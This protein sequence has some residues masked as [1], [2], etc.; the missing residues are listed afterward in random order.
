MQNSTTACF[1]PQ[2]LIKFQCYVANQHC[3]TT[4]HQQTLVFIFCKKNTTNFKCDPLCLIWSNLEDNLWV[5]KKRGIMHCLSILV[6]VFLGE[7]VIQIE[8]MQSSVAT[9]LHIFSILFY[10]K[11]QKWKILATLGLFW[12]MQSGYIAGCIQKSVDSSLCLI[13]LI[14]FLRS[15]MVYLWRHCYNTFSPFIL[16]ATFMLGLEPL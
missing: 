6:T 7:N 1:L 13:G 3:I 8:K 16:D 12:C 14:V 2:N 9:N 5:Q 10:N 4:K 15:L 11:S